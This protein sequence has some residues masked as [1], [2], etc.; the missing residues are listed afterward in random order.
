[1]TRRGFTLIELL[2]VIAIIAILA[3]ILFPVFAKAREKARQSSCLSNVKQLSLAI[4]QYAQD[5]DERYPMG[6]DLGSPRCGII[7]STQPY[8]K[9]FQVHD[10]PSASEKSQNS[11][12]GSR[13]YGY[14]TSLIP[15][16]VTTIPAPTL[17][18]VTRPAQIVLLGDVCQDNNATFRFAMPTTGPF[19][20]DADGSHCKVCG[21]T[22]NSRYADT[23]H[24]S[25]Y[26][27]PGF[28]FIERH[29]GMGN[30]AFCDGHAKAMKQTELYQ[31]GSNHPY[32]DYLVQ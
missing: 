22:H 21:G 10:C 2:V 17:G 31:N 27:R 14:H 26:D 15:G 4:M 20:C 18:E 30:V 9:N 3:A 8:T 16:G 29:N 32:F 23:G 25:I 5:Y 24:G 1:M 13:S 28:N 6:Y 19:Q 11:Y 12:L 7:Q